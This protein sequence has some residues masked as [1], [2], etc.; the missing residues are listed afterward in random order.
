MKHA[1]KA[2]IVVAMA[3]PIAATTAQ[4][5]QQKWRAGES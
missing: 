4:G 1:L 3:V 5:H 2:V